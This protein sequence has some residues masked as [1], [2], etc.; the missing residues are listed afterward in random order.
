MPPPTPCTATHANTTPARHDTHDRA[1]TTDTLPNLSCRPLPF[2]KTD[3]PWLIVVPL[4]I[5]GFLAWSPATSTPRRSRSQKFE[6]WVESS[7]GVEL[8]ELSTD[9]RSGSTRLPSIVLVARRFRRQ[10]GALQAGLRHR[11]FGA[12][13]PH[14]A[15]PGAR[16]RPRSWSTSTTSTTCTRRSSST[17]IAHPIAQAAYWI[18]QHVID[19]IVNAVGDRRSQDR[20]LGLPQRRPACGRRR[21]QRQ[22]AVATRHRRRTAAGAIRQGQPVRSAAVR[23]R[24]RR[25]ARTR[26]R[27]HARGTAWKYSQRPTTGCSALGTFLPL[28]GVLVMLFIPKREEA[29]VKQIAHRHRGGHAGASAS[30]R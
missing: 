20:R 10:P 23:C 1:P 18:N 2:A 25:R 17:A 30:T 4:M 27:Q 24:S 19:G 26:H 15:Q 13:G 16:R 6:R 12:Q 5:L 8:P 28:A 11:A 22:R 14:P 9:V 3:S 21:G 29:L 7:I